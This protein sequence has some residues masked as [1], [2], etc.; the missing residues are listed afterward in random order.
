M[1]NNG[2]RPP[3]TQDERE[4][5]RSQR[6]VTQ[7]LIADERR[8][9]L[10]IKLYRDGMPQTEIT[11]RLSRASRAGGGGDIGEDAVNKLVARYKDREDFP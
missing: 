4:L 6:I 10:I 2:L 7:G 8:K 5:E 3:R 11:A 1:S 9:R